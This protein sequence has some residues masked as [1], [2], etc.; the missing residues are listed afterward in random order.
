MVIPVLLSVMYSYG[1]DYQAQGRYIYSAFP[2]LA[3]FFG[4]AYSKLLSRIQSQKICSAVT[5]ALCIVFIAF[6]LQSFF[7]T[8]LPT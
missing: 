1:N 8:Y 5:A 3:V 4:T 6:N 7:G 2:G